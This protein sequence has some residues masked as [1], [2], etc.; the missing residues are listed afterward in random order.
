MTR[1]LDRTLSPRDL[2]PK[3]NRT[4]ALSAAKIQ[5]IEDTWRAGDGAPV[6][7]VEGRYQA[8]GWT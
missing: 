6:F 7:T 5:S 8:R 1:R 2:L 4:F 3:I